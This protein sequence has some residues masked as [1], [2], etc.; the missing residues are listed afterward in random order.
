MRMDQVVAV[1][2]SN[3]DIRQDV[4]R[5]LWDIPTVRT[6]NPPLTLEVSNGVV[7]ISGVVRSRTMSQQIHATAAAVEGV[8][9][10]HTN[11]ENDASIELAVAHRLS[12]DEELRRWS[13]RIWV[14]AYHGDVRLEGPIAEP[15]VAERAAELAATVPGVRQVINELA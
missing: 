6:T 8:K 13:P 3:E 5:A 12:A 11:V 7:T 14:S 2:R 15:A 9:E 4:E 1:E 10:V